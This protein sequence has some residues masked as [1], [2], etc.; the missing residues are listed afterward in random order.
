M[1]VFT[2]E[3][4]Y[5]LP[6][7]RHRD[8]NA[9]TIAAACRLAIDDDDWDVGR[10]DYESAHESFV[11]GIWPGAK[12]AYSAPSLTVPAH[13]GE[14][15]Q[16]KARHFETLLGLLKMM[17]VDIRAGST[18][19]S[20]WVSRAAWAVARGEAILAGAKDPKMVGVGRGREALSGEGGSDA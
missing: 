4:T 3:T 6:V 19:S 14:T 18:P 17:M 16:R 9:R 7:F 2:I 5:H 10:P 15:I 1:P 8:Y 11:S 20:E 13:F 12:A